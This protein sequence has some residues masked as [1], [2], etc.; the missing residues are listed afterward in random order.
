MCFVHAHVTR[1]F[2]PIGNETIPPLPRRPGSSYT[3]TS[4]SAFKESS[5]LRAL[6]NFPSDNSAF[7]FQLLQIAVWVFCFKLAVRDSRCVC[8]DG[9]NVSH[10]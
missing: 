3:P 4:S 2:V 9:C 8:F 7:L 1:P 10:G 5:S 6:T